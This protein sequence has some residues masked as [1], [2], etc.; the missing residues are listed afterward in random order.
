MLAAKRRELFESQVS[1]AGLDV[2][3][4]WRG[5][6][7]PRLNV[8]LSVLIENTP[9]SLRMN[10]TDTSSKILELYSRDHSGRIAGFSGRQD[11]TI[12]AF[13]NRGFYNEINQRVALPEN[14]WPS[15][16]QPHCKLTLSE[17]WDVICAATGKMNYASNSWFDGT[18]ARRVDK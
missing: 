2:L 11:G 1:K 7:R 17:L 18:T 5:D 4:N 14:M 15:K 6:V 9:Y 3:E 10:T 8:M 16:S 12:T 13:F